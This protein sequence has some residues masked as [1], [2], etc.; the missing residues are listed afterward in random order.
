MIP[1]FEA[2]VE[3]RI[4]KAQKNGAFDSLEGHGKPL[5][6]EEAQV[7]NE[8]RMAHKIL[9]NAGFLPPEIEL[10]KQI[11]KTEQLIETLDQG[12]CEFKK[13]QKRLNYLLTKLAT[14]RGSDSP[15]AVS[16]YRDSII[17]KLS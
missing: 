4:R 7:P 8:L 2:I 13:N 5:N 15:M 3:Q 1:G 9:K 16:P 14:L 17:E 10:R 12:S 6:M 11:T